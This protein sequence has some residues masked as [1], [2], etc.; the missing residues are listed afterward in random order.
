M[1]LWLDFCAVG[2]GSV[3]WVAIFDWRQRRRMTK[4]ERKAADDHS[5]DGGWH[6]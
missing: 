3:I 5:D 2:I 4:A 6:W 1:N